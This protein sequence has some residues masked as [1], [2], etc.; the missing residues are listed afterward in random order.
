MARG[1]FLIWGGLHGGFLIVN[2]GWR[3]LRRGRPDGGA[4][5]RLA[6]WA[7]TFL[8]VVVAWVFFR[9]PDLSTACDV[10]AGMAGLHGPAPALGP[11]IGKREA[12]TLG[13]LL[14]VALLMPNIR[15]IMRG[16]VLVLEAPPGPARVDA[17]PA[18]RLR[19]RPGIAWA[20]ACFGLFAVSLLDMTRVSQ[21][22]YF[23]F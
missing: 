11:G 17:F 3:W 14:G 15:E 7:L 21:F 9:A 6:G 23:R 18:L 13:V 16:E 1:G 22:L 2:H 19:W 5:G 8:C 12:V 20:A 10:L 4:A